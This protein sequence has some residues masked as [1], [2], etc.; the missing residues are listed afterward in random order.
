MAKVGR[1]GSGIWL[2]LVQRAADGSG[3]AAAHPALLGAAA[4]ETVLVEARRPVGRVRL[5]VVEVEEEGARQGVEGGEG[6]LV[7]AHRR[8]PG[9]VLEEQ[10]EAAP[11]TSVRVVDARAAPDHRAGRDRGGRPAAGVEE[12]GEG[13]EA[14]GNADPPLGLPDEA[15]GELRGEERVDRGEG[16]AGLAARVGED[17]GLAREGVERR[18]RRARIAVGPEVV[19]AQGID[20]DEDDVELPRLAAAGAGREEGRGGEGARRAAEHPRSVAQRHSGGASVSADGPPLPLHPP[21]A[22]GAAA[23]VSRAVRA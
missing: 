16:A 23:G 3:I 7:D 21:P 11:E 12:L 15:L 10:V 8:L 2:S 9:A 14:V 4:R 20:E 5:E 22:A 1:S 19:G 13:R 6:A 17:D 18:A